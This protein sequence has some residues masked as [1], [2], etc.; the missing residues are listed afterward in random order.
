MTISNVITSCNPHNDSEEQNLEHHL[1]MAI[2]FATFVFT[3]TIE[4]ELF[5]ILNV[6]NTNCQ[7]QNNTYMPK[8]NTAEIFAE[9]FIR[10]IHSQNKYTAKCYFSKLENGFQPK[11][12]TLLEF[13]K[14]AIPLSIF[15]KVWN[16][17]GKAY[18]RKLYNNTNYPDYIWEYIRTC[19][20][21]GIDAMSNN[22]LPTGPAEYVDYNL[23][24]MCNFIDSL[25]IGIHTETAYNE[26][27]EQAIK[28]ADFV[29]ERF[30]VKTIARISN[31][32]Y[33]ESKIEEI[34]QFTPH[35][36]R[37]LKN[38]SKHILILDKHVHWQEWV[39]ANK[40]AREI[41]FVISPSNKGGYVIQ[42]VPN[43]FN[44]NGYRK[45][46]PKKWWG[47]NG[48]H[49]KKVTKNPAASFVHESYGFIAGAETL[50]GAIALCERAFSHQ[51]C[52]KIK[53][54]ER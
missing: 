18:C 44:Q 39:I 30:L 46:F 25:S 41:W 5:K 22:I 34:L 53:N 38:P 36:Q 10:R 54:I 45:G 35:S 13:T 49:L 17:Y 52:E 50:S 1:N 12:N 15:G 8:F 24:S 9:A 47:L 28:I 19:L 33:V 32:S 21:S 23:L 14:E 7:I 6:T 20:V 11:R 31:R 37:N 16:L 26:A 40:Q 43:K 2:E 51:E 42:P 48:E 4:K 29:I 27:K 3:R